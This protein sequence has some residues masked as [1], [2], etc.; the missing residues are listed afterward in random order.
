MKI[1]LLLILLLQT[2]STAEFRIGSPRIEMLTIA[3]VRA[4]RGPMRLLWM[5]ATPVAAKDNGNDAC[6]VKFEQLGMTSLDDL[7]LRGDRTLYVNPGETVD[8]NFDL[9]R[10]F[11]GTDF[12]AGEGILVTPQNCA[13]IAL[14]VE[15]P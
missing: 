12:K 14:K 13:T 10:K 6:T 15:R 7:K 8:W 9:L 5:R 4:I 11:I 1:S 2:T 3:S